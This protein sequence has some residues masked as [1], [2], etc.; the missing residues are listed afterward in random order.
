ML[1]NRAAIILIA[2]LLFSGQILASELPKIEL[3]PWGN[4]YCF[5][6]APNQTATGEGVEEIEL[7]FSTS[8]NSE[9]QILYSFSQEV[10]SFDIEVENTFFYLAFAIQDSLYLTYSR[11]NGQTFSSPILFSDQGKNPCLAIQ[12]DLL[13]IAWEEKDGIHYCRSEDGGMNF[14]ETVTLMI[15]G[16]VLS[17]PTLSIDRLKHAHLTFL[18]EDNNTN[19]KQIMYT[20]LASP[21]PRVLFESHDHIINLG[22]K[23]L[24]DASPNTSGA[25]GLLV[26]WQKEYLERRETCFSISLDGGRTFSRE[27][28]LEFE[29]DLLALSFINDKFSAVTV[30]QLGTGPAIQEIGL[31]IL[32]APH[33]L[34]P[35]EN[36]VIN[37]SDL[38]LDY[39]FPSRDP[40]IC[41]IDLSQ[42]NSFPIGNSWSFEQLITAATQEV[43]QY[44]LPEDLA[45][46]TYFLQ[47]QTS[48][49]L[50]FGP[51]SQTLAFRIDNLSPQILTLEAEKS[52]KLVIFKGELSE[53]P[54][55]LT[56][57]GKAV[58]LE[59]LSQNPTFESEFILSPG[60]NCF[61]FV[62]TD[63]AGNLQIATQEVF[64][65]PA[66]PEITVLKPEET[67][68]FKP[69]ST[70]FIEAHVSDVQGDIEDGS[71]VEI[72]INHELLEETLIFDQQ[73]SRLFGFVS[74]PAEL[75]NGK[76]PGTISISDRSGNK[77]S[78]DFTLNIDGLP[79]IINHP[80]GEPT[81]TNSQTTFVISALEEGAGIDPS[82]T[83]V[84]I[85]GVSL[86]GTL[87]VEAQEIIFHADLPIPEGTHEVEVVA[88]DQIGNLGEP[89]L[90]FLIVDTHAPKLTLLGSY[91]ATTNQ[92]K[93][94]VQGKI[95]EDYPSSINI[96]NNQQV[97][98]NFSLS[99]NSFSE[100][101]GLLP[102]MNEIRIEV[103]DKAGNKSCENL[104]ILA[105]ISATAASGLIVNCAHGP[106]PFSPREKLPGAFSTHGRGMIFSYA[107]SQP[108]DIKILIYDLTGTLIWTKEIENAASGITAWSG[109]DNFGHTAGN[110]IYPYIFSASSG[111]KNEIRRGKILIIN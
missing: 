63:E 2:I 77:G 11:D 1:N 29:K 92:S 109:V 66:L 18:S 14:S 49:G 51:L 105:N 13:S 74:L 98:K 102:G 80:P 58:S 25:Q 5:W 27:K 110:G 101:I 88:R 84:R 73:E 16:E 22:I 31:P 94:T 40:F 48:D 45:D 108:A 87:S 37:S 32:S 3:D 99:G 44:E 53:A 57:N 52:E 81:F 65:D 104:S 15:T 97:V 54:A 4:F 8:Y 64:Y 34:F 28:Y 21:E 50:S 24:P 90:F 96:Y 12:D 75:N 85:S 7:R 46:G 67:E 72:L 60:E 17:T 30:D 10:T 69:D 42:D 95:E 83:L 103:L 36:A 91:E 89:V 79:P 56:I 93:I 59:A 43:F 41:K 78:R 35:A 82:G 33:L 86:E 62:L 6:L 106:N 100:E 61:T 38:K 68:W 47:A 39:T 107:L 26:F 55:W 71:E 20:R 76:Y 19:L 23:I 70:I 111:G 9:P